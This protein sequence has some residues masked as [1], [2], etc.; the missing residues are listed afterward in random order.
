MAHEFETKEALFP[1]SVTYMDF[2]LNNACG[3]T[4]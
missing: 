4:C 2:P 1:E 3:G